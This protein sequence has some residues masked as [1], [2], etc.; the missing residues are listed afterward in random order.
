M[1]FFGPEEILLKRST[2]CNFERRENPTFTEKK[3]MT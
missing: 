1:T 3:D 2:M